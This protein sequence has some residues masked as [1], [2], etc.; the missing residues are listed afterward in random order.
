MKL[1]DTIQPFL[2]E[3]RQFVKMSTLATYM[4]MYDRHIIPVFGEKDAIRKSDIDEFLIYLKNE[5]KLGKRTLEHIVTALKSLLSYCNR[6][7]F[8]AYENKNV[9][10]PKYEDEGREINPLTNKEAGVLAKYCEENF[11]FDSLIIYLGLFTG[12]R[13]GELC[14]VQF[15]DVDVDKGVIT[16]GK[17]IYRVHYGTSA[18][19]ISEKKTEILTQT[20][21]TA[22]SIREIPL[23]KNLIKIFKALF[24]I[25]NQDFYIATNSLVP[26]EPSVIRKR[27][28]HILKN[29]G[30]RDI[31]LHDLRHTFATRCISV[32]IDFKTVSELLGHSS[33]STTLNIYMHTDDDTKSKAIGTLYNLSLIHI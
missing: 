15:K 7:G 32:G 21:K 17:T 5:K 31:R 30:I 23:T 28:K 9:T 3:K 13:A 29:A 16:V 33:V 24:K 1:K 12:M 10:Y 22:H 20:P 27:F 4:D 25:V 8:I 18:R 14:G 11:N 19:T 6:K 26:T 2:E